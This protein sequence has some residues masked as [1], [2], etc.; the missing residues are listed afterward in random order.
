MSFPFLAKSQPIHV[1]AL[2]PW[3][4]ADFWKF[5]FHVFRNATAL[6]CCVCSSAVPTYLCP[7]VLKLFHCPTN[8]LLQSL[9]TLVEVRNNSSFI[10]WATTTM[11]LLSGMRPM[12][13]PTTSA[14]R[15]NGKAGAGH[16]GHCRSPVR[17]SYEV[18]CS[19]GRLLPSHCQEAGL[20]FW[21]LLLLLNVC[22]PA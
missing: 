7:L 17:D 2:V 14:P 13:G 10:L 16:R 3:E 1:N 20:F 12:D 19:Q 4:V 5:L 9:F 8:P 6:P 11:E 22:Y 21:G 15:G 18:T